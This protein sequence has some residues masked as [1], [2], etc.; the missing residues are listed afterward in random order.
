MAARQSPPDIR[1]RR[2]VDTMTNPTTVDRRDVAH[3]T[4]P[5]GAQDHVEEIDKASHVPPARSGQSADPAEPPAPE[6]TNPG[7]LDQIRAEGRKTAHVQ[8][9]VPRY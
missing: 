8:S 2:K 9:P 7:R 4:N 3:P 1:P 6:D 5:L